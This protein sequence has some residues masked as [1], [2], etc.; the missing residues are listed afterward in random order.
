HVVLLPSPNNPTG[1]A[2]PPDAVSVLCEAAASAGHGGIVVVDEAYGEFRRSGTPSA[3][4]MLPQHRNL[5]V[6]RTLSKAFALP[7]ARVGSFAARREICDAVRVGRLPYHL[8]AV[9]PASARAA[10]QRAP[11]R[12]ARVEALWRD[13]DASVDWLR[14]QG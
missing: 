9:S 7:G 2:L 10:L 3:L 1:T 6:A 12:L 5:V 11:G 8:S 13:G 14:G 4:E